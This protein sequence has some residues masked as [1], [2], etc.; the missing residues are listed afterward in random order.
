MGI[1]TEF[2]QIKQIVS[3]IS[4]A[5]IDFM[6]II[7][8]LVLLDRAWD[9]KFWDPFVASI[10]AICPLW[11]TSNGEIAY[12]A[13]GNV[14][15]TAL[16]VNLF[17]KFFPKVILSLTLLS[18]KATTRIGLENV[19]KQMRNLM[20]ATDKISLRKDVCHQRPP[21]RDPIIAINE[22]IRTANP[23]PI[24]LCLRKRSWHISKQP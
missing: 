4:L 13:P 15:V 10:D 16:Y 3:I 6:L 2:V 11:L 17:C 18:S 5:R 23:L 22:A 9:G 14:T 12:Y 7:F 19:A 24:H 1:V 21:T 8:Y 20:S